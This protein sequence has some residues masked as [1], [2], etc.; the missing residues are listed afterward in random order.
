MNT[1]CQ[2][3][4]NKSDLSWIN[5]SFIVAVLSTRVYISRESTNR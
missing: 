1:V 4:S 3:D 2:A 5:I